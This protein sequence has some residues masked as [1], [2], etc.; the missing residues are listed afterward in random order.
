LDTLKIFNVNKPN[1]DYSQINIAFI[2][3]SFLGTCF[4]RTPKEKNMFS[5]NGLSSK[6]HFICK[7]TLFNYRLFTYRKKNCVSRF[8]HYCW[9]QLMQHCT[10]LYRISVWE[11]PQS[12]WCVKWSM[13]LC[14]YLPKHSTANKQNKP[15]YDITN[16]LPI[17]QIRFQ[18]HYCC[19][20]RKH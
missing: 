16:K 4:L 1:K 9:N 20:W 6:Q 12:L 17:Y 5:E 14:V 15:I 13:C 18:W 2:I 8:A 11:P 10:Y 3:T 7:S 19:I